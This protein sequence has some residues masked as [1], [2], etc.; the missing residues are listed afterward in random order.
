MDDNMLCCIF[1]Y[2]FRQG[3][4]LCPFTHLDSLLHI[5]HLSLVLHGLYRLPG[6]SYIFSCCFPLLHFP[7]IVPIMK[8]LQFLSSHQDVEKGCLIHICNV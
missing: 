4:R 6:S 3:R 8:M 2:E 1:K 7:L 5:V